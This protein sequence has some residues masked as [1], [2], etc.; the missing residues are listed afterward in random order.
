[1]T[2][3]TYVFRDRGG[4][5]RRTSLAL[6]W[7]VYCDPISDEFTPDDVGA[8]EL[9]DLWIQRYPTDKNAEAMWGEGAVGIHWGVVGDGIYEFAPFQIGV[10]PPNE[11]FLTYFSWP[12]D[13]N[14]DALAWSRVTVRDKLWRR[15][16]GDKGGFIQEY[17]GWKPSPLQ[18]FVY[19]QQL[20]WMV[21]RNIDQGVAHV[22]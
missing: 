15:T 17:T 21:G 14:G 16:Q 22:D 12:R 2:P 6:H 19:R 11:T 1:M 7:E 3:R 8:R 18:P 10:D 4:H 9:F 5:Q 20:L 13:Q